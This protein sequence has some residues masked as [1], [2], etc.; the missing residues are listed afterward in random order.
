MTAVCQDVS[1]DVA[2]CGCARGASAQYRRYV[3]CA[4]VH[5]GARRIFAHPLEPA[6]S[7]QVSRLNECTKPN[8]APPHTNGSGAHCGGAPP[9]ALYREGGAR[10]RT[11]RVHPGHSS[12]RYVVRARASSMSIETASKT[13]ERIRVQAV[14]ASA[15]NRPR[16]RASRGFRSSAQ[17]SGPLA[18]TSHTIAHRPVRN[19]PDS[20]ASLRMSTNDN[21]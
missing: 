9:P 8:G 20:A 3:L 10:P 12:C 21:S 6:T 13:R 4:V 15:T 5:G 2:R 19:R 16:D 11:S 7:V 18:K 1:L 17:F 14:S